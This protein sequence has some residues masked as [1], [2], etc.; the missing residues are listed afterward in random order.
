MYRV[1]SKLKNVKY[2][3]RAWNKTKVQ[4]IFEH[5][6][7]EEHLACSQNLFDANPFNPDV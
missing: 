5:A 2:S 6:I 1:V 7:R 4:D 3:L